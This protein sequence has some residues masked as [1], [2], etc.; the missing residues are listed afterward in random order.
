MLA[1]PAVL[2]AGARRRASAL[3]LQRITQS[4]LAPR[5]QLLM[6]ASA[7]QARRLLSSS[8]SSSNLSSFHQHISPQKT[9]EP[10]TPSSSGARKPLPS[11]VLIA[12][13]GEIA[14]RVM[15]TC[16]ALG[17]ATVAVYSEADAGA[18]HVAQAD[19]AYCIG[20]APSSES[21]LDMRKIVRVAQLSGAQAVHPGY[22][23]LSE[24]AAFAQLLA[25]SGIEFIGPPASAI[26]S[27]GSKSA[28][29]EIMLAA[30]VPCVPGY[31]GAEQDAAFLQRE[32]DKIGYPV[33]IKAVKGG[34]GKG[35]KIA[36]SA[37]D[38]AEQLQSA[39]REGA[40]SFGDPTV[41]LEKYLT[42]PRH[43]EVQVMC[44][45]LGNAIYV[46]ERDCS[47]QRRHQKI[48]EEAPAPAS[49]RSSAASSA[50]RPSPPP[51]RSTTSARARSSSCSTRIRWSCE[52]LLSLGRI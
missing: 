25:E 20:P 11:K 19:E 8:S 30:G 38:F 7:S 16:R 3:A 33:L 26:V 21:Y 15:R 47:V 24:N 4:T 48:I 17:I 29:K 41:L 31:H 45:K 22:G 34:G 1:L 14:C 5:A 37:A 49:A 28:S 32:A 12:N 50:R 2:K 52:C 6:P 18:M 43:V 40:K 9:L 51:R 36:T 44:D 39:Q 46:W 23:F 35:M 10:L 42:K 27:M 13:R